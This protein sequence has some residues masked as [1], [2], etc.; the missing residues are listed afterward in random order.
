[1]TS[2]YCKGCAL[3]LPNRQLEEGIFRCSAPFFFF[4]N[5]I[6]QRFWCAAPY[7]TAP[8]GTESRDISRNQ[9]TGINQSCRHRNISYNQT[10]LYSLVGAMDRYP[11]SNQRIILLPQQYASIQYVQANVFLT[12]KII[13]QQFYLGCCIFSK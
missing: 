3:L 9:V 4:F 10:I 5:F 6:L 12:I 13:F 7:L 8:K 11:D 1:M 2:A